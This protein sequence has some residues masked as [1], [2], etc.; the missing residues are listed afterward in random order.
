MRWV[1][2]LLAALCVGLA[3]ATEA[4]A[5]GVLSCTSLVEGEFA[6]TVEAAPVPSLR[7]RGQRPD[8]KALR[9]D[10]SHVRSG[11]VEASAERRPLALVRVAR[12]ARATAH[13]R[14]LLLCVLRC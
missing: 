11:V 8:L 3:P 10:A 4:G 6:A 12:D 13:A 5:T 7:S 2:L 1:W 14:H 9:G